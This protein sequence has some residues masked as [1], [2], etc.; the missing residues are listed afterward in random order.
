M[1]RRRPIDQKLCNHIGMQTHRIFGSGLIA[2]IALSAALPAVAGDTPAP[3]IAAPAPAKGLSETAAPPTPAAAAPPNQIWEC[4]T[5][6]VRTFSSNPCGSKSVVRELNPVNV[7]QPP[8]AYHVTHTS[9]PPPVPT[10]NYSYPTEGGSDAANT[11]NAYNGYP[12]YIAVPRAH[13]VHTNPA[14]NHP[15]PHHP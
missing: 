3:T 13:R 10:A 15:R 1:S 12:A 6:G 9:A 2:A 14:H 8:P 5:N 7:M 4:T 11:D